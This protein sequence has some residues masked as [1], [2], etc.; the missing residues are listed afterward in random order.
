MHV[1]VSAKAGQGQV[2]DVPP[3]DGAEE[4]HAWRIVRERGRARRRSG[5]GG[6]LGIKLSSGIGVG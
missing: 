4:E 3:N 6:D 5:K 2:H 1:A